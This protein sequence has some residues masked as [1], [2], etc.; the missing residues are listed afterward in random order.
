MPC[1]ISWLLINVRGFF[2][3]LDLSVS[4]HCWGCS[5][6]LHS[7]GGRSSMRSLGYQEHP[8]MTWWHALLT[9]PR[10]LWSPDFRARLLRSWLGLGCIC[11]FATFCHPELIFYGSVW[12]D[13]TSPHLISDGA[14]LSLVPLCAGHCRYV[15]PEILLWPLSLSKSM[16]GKLRKACDTGLAWVDGLNSR[17]G[18]WNSSVMREEVP[19]HGAFGYSIG[20]W[21]SEWICT[22]SL[23]LSF[24][25]QH[26][27]NW[28]QV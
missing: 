4:F 13:L 5:T 11:F 10:L 14:L 23:T 3:P 6:S 15:M 7:T 18:L 2:F 28:H 22:T 21:L 12:G 20:G 16:Q 1:S 19:R 25:L 27:T 26:P 17:Q 9:G 8:W 24:L